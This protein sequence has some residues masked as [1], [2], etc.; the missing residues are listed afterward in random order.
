MG[1][2]GYFAE[3]D[4]EKVQHISSAQ[5][6]HDHLDLRKKGIECCA[7]DGAN[8]HND[9]KSGQYAQVKAN[10]SAKSQP[11]GITHGKQIVGTRCVSRNKT[12]NQKIV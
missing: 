12:I 1:M 6:L 7:E 10:A 3:I 2:I 4:S 5:D 11:Y 9:C 8:R